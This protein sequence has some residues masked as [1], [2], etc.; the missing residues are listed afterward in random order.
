MHALCL[1]VGVT[2]VMHVFC[3][4]LLEGHSVFKVP[5]VIDELTT[6]RVITMELVSGVPLDLCVDLDQETRNKVS[7]QTVSVREEVLKWS[8]YPKKS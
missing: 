5:E 6:S 4:T 7:E 1:C 3:R 2:D 8:M